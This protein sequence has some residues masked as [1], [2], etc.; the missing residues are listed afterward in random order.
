MSS[1]FE[2]L[3]KARK[4]EKTPTK[5]KPESVKKESPSPPPVTQ[6][7]EAAAIA[8]SKSSEFEQ[9]LIYLKKS[10]KKEV[11]KTLLDDPQGRNF[12]DLVEELL[13]NWLKQQK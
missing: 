13:T 6:S 1:Q 7:A 9:A 5:K 12:S 2:E 4:E 11:K 10:T 3:F 8:K